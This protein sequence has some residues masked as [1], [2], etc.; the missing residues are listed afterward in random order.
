MAE[1][2]G[3]RSTGG[4]SLGDVLCGKC[5]MEEA[6]SEGP[7][8]TTLL[9]NHRGR[10]K[11]VDGSRRRKQSL[12]AELNA[13]GDRFDAIVIDS[14]SGSTTATRRLWLRAT[15]VVLV[16]TAE[17]AAV[18]DA[19]AALKRH[20]LGARGTTCGHIRLLV[21]RAETDR[22][23]ADA[24]RRLTNCCQRFLRQSVAALPAL[25]VLDCDDASVGMWPR[26]W[27]APNSE[28]GRAALWLGRA[29]SDAVEAAMSSPD[30]ACTFS[31]NAK[32]NSSAKVRNHL[33]Q[34]VSAT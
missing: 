21:N 14:G 19:Y 24:H 12:L 5:K 27:E 34:W 20:T 17:D 15:L 29:V 11:K 22:V 9:M 23:A 28:F 1:I 31:T 32:S 8:G 30:V 18:M 2:A 13:I 25:P 6:L 33:G 4:M 26:V 3:L 7:A 10:T 16:S